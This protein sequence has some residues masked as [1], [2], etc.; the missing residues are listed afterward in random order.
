MDYHRLTPR[1][2]A[3]RLYV[4]AVDSV[5]FTVAALSLYRVIVTPMS[6]YWLVIVGL[7]AI[8]ALVPITI[9]G[10]NSRFSVGDI[11]IFINTLLFGPA[12]GT[13]T[14]AVDGLIGSARLPGGLR[15][16]RAAA[17]NTAA[18]AISVA[19]A[20]QV[21]FRVLG[22]APLARGSAVD[23]G[24]LALPLALLALVHYFCNSVIVA[25]VV[26]LD[27]RGGLL[28]IWRESFVAP[29]VVYLSNAAWA[30]IIAGGVKSV[31]V[32]SVALASLVALVTHGTFRAYAGQAIAVTGKAGLVD[33]E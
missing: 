33:K 7:A 14:A 1:H 15:R 12:A 23:L 29:A 13:V 2:P 8:T 30:G 5:G 28:R 3:Y 26:A 31:T 25:V 16:L 11:L 6:A 18:M 10:V 20:G 22:A 19:L 4:L 9:P 27:S 32:T 24:R 21:F 17:F